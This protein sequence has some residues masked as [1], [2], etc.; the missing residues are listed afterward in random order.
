MKRPLT[1]ILSVALVASILFAAWSW[2][3]PYEWRPDPGARF[4]IRQAKLTRDHSN[5][6]LDVFLERAGDVDHDLEKPVFL[7][8]ASGRRL[9]PADTTL[10]GEGAKGTTAL[11][12]RF[13]LEPGDLEGSLRLHLNDGTLSIRS[14]SGIPQTG[15]SGKFFLS[16][17]W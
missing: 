7:E 2:F 3:R 8:T 10:S 9:D 17:H 16:N 15:D 6:W 1:R 12:F 11:Y 4:H 13:W 5:H 14:G